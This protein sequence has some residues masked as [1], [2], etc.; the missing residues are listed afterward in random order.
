MTRCPDDLSQSNV[1]VAFYDGSANGYIFSQGTVEYRP[2]KLQ[3]SSSLM[4]SGGTPFKRPVDGPTYAKIANALN[5]A[6]DA[7]AVHI[8]N[9]TMLSGVIHIK[10]GDETRDWI[11]A[12][13]SAEL[14]AIETL[15]D[16]LKKKETRS[17][18]P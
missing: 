18:Q 1:S 15:M 16:E 2:V 3:E 14:S 11:I 12:P 9:R 7:K 4:Y 6:I 5:A 8:P 10:C 17:S 13:R